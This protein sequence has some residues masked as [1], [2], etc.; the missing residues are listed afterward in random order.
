[1]TTICGAI[2]GVV[3]ALLIGGVALLATDDRPMPPS[4]WSGDPP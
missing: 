4:Y 3:A 2:L 1:M